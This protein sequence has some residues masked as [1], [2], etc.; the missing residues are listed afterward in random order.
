MACVMIEDDYF[1]KGI[2]Q[3]P[4]FCYVA[5]GGPAAYN[6]NTRQPYMN[7]KIFT[8]RVVPF[9][10]R[11]FPTLCEVMHETGMTKDASDLFLHLHRLVQRQSPGCPWK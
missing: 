10:T 6:I 4:F 8:F 1:G 2:A 7:Y 5:M 11:T 9:R 3:G